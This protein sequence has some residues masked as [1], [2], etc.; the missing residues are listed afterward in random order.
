MTLV[1]FMI[2]LLP[3]DPAQEIAAGGIGSS[4]EQIEAIRVRLGLDKPLYE[5]YW[6]FVKR[7]AQGD[8]GRSIY[9]NRPVST[10]IRERVGATLQLTLAGIGVAILIGVP[11][12]IVAAVRQNSWVDSL[13]M[14]VALTGVAMPSFWLGLLLIWLFAV[15]LNWLPIIGGSGIKGLILPAFTLGFGAA[16]LIARLVRSSMLEVLRQD[17]M[18]TARAKGLTGRV[19][20]LNHGLKNALIPV[21]TIVGLQFGNLLGGAVV[22]ETVFARQGIGRMAIDGILTKD[23]PVVQGTVLFA[24]LVYVTVN[25]AVDLLYSVLDPRIR[26]D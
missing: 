25:L 11:L 20:V 8:L 17:Y 2:H 23:F 26:Y 10:M 13:S 21:V 14:T 16:A 6:Q 19:V 22:I 4:P 9:R 1:F 5:Q 15:R 7:T 18:L 3:G 12:G 24:A